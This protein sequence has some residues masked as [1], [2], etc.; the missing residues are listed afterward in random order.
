MATLDEQRRAIGDAMEKSRRAIGDRMEKSRRAAGDAMVARR[1][2]RSVQADV[3]ALVNRPR[4]RP[5]LPPV[6]SRGGLPAQVGVGSYGGNPSGGGKGGIASPLT[7]QADGR[8]YYPDGLPSSDGLLVLPAIK[9]LSFLDSNGAE[10]VFDFAELV[11][12]P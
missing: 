8:E 11:A 6:Q 7:E 5:T 2:G 3:N 4:Q 1:T 12:L 9:K 10:A